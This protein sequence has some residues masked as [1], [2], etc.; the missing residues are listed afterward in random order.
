MKVKKFELL[1]K[2]HFGKKYSEDFPRGFQRIGHVAVIGVKPGVRKHE[3]GIAG[4]VLK[5]YP[6]IKTVCRKGRVEGELRKPR[7]KKIVGN[8]TVTTHKEN[9]CTYT[10]DVSKVMF[11]KGNLAERARIV[12]QVKDNE[13]VVDMFAGIGYFSIPIAKSKNVKVVGIEKNMDSVKYLKKNILQ[14]NVKILPILGDSLYSPLKIKA[15]RIIMGYMPKTYRYLPSAFSILRDKGI[16]HY[17]DTYGK[18]ELWEK[19]LGIIKKEAA[20]AGFRVERIVKKRVVK[21]YA[22]NVYH[23]VIDAEFKKQKNY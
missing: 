18:R 5:N 21:N 4:L 23:I 11:A 22:P 3:K 19:P 10:L 1:L 12:S 2:E 13:T 16:I 14:N 20:K 6:H 8:G 17:H 9:Y 7:I 15:D